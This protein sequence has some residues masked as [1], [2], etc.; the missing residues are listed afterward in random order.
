V[1]G[2]SL[3]KE[4]EP[5]LNA[6]AK[7]SLAWTHVSDLK[8]WNSLVVPLYGIEEIPFNV[9]VDPKGNV[10]AQNLQG[11]SLQ[12]KLQEVLK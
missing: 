2:V 12:Q 8:F 4:R 7:D 1:L 3:D 9:L 5:W 6:I 10:I 11:P